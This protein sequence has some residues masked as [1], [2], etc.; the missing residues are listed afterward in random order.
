[1][2]ALIKAHVDRLSGW[3]TLRFPYDTQT[4]AVLKTYPGARWDPRDKVWLAP[5]DLWEGVLKHVLRHEIGMTQ[6]RR[7]PI[8]PNI[9][10]RLR[11]YQLTGAEF[12]IR[13]RGALLTMQMRTGKTPTVIAAATA[14]MGAGQA[15]RLIV[16]YPGAVVGE[17]VRQ[18][19]QWANLNL[20]PMEGNDLVSDQEVH[21][22]SCVRFLAL[23]CHYEILDK[24]VSKLKDEEDPAQG[25]AFIGDIDRI[26]GNDPFIL[27]ADEVHACKNRKAG[28][29]KALHRLSAMPNCIARWGLSGTPMRNSPRDLF[30][31]FEFINPKSMSGYW[32]F[33]KRYCAAVLGEN[34]YW[35]DKGESNPEE[36]SARLKVISYSK[37]REDPDVAPYLPKAQRHVIQCQA[38]AALQK[39]YD[40]MEKELA[41]FV[42]PGLADGDG[43]SMQSREAVKALT[44]MV[45]AAKIPTAIKRCYEHLDADR[46]VVVFAHFH[47][48]LQAF[49]EAAEKD[50][51][52]PIWIATGWVAPEKRDERIESWKQYKGGGILVCSTIASGMGIDLSD[53]DISLFLEFEW[54]PADFRQAEDRQVD[55][56]LGKKKGPPV[57]EYLFVKKTIDEAMGGALLRKIRSNVQ[58]VGADSE[59]RGVSTAL[60]GAGVVGP[61]RL[62]LESTDRSTVVAAIQAAVGRWLDDKP[63]SSEATP[64]N[65]DGWEDVEDA[66]LVD[67]SESA[68]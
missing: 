52:F 53:A 3:A 68:A 10:G 15:I 62:G 19:R 31:L 35:E 27:I 5:I 24:H 56:H 66:E 18:L 38:P 21:R 7:A 55:M 61:S 20:V 28:R 17:W 43:V 47:E 41:T 39:Q 2:A 51:T 37:L 29:T 46:K 33:A 64:I 16:T 45:S 58:I 60:R 30:G 42:K 13:N 1:M 36:L 12:L 63:A 32:T 22:L 23:G 49:I 67:E 54:V 4:V 50:A 9:G 40:S 14:L 57:F 8:H 25:F 34:G 6:E 65:F 26:V 11:P 59:M 48:T 44:I